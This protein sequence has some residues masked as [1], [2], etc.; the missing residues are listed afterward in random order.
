LRFSRKAHSTRQRS[1][2]CE[3]LACPLGGLTCFLGR[4]SERFVG[5]SCTFGYFAAGLLDIAH[6]LA[7]GPPILVLRSTIFSPDTKPLGDTTALLGLSAE[8][9]CFITALFRRIDE[10]LP[11]VAH[12]PDPLVLA[13]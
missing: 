8:L 3:N 1:Q 10:S 11:V 6:P 7:I 5:L 13:A 4:E 9:L 2:F 12:R